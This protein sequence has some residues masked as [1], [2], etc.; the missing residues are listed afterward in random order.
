ML[1]Y[2]ALLFAVLSACSESTATDDPNTVDLSYSF[3]QGLTDWQ[4]GAT[5]IIVG[6]NPIPWHIQPSSAIAFDGSQSL[7]FHMANFTDAAKIWITR[8]V[9][10]QPNKDYHVR[11]SYELATRDWGDAN[12]FSL[13][14]GAFPKPPATAADLE[15]A[16][17]RF[18]T[19]NGASSDVGYRWLHK[20]VESSVRTG[21]DGKAHIVVGVWGTYE[22]TRTYYIDAV[23]IHLE[24]A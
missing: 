21:A 23:R 20:E 15:P 11:V 10:L 8:A 14:T 4:T 5:D 17:I 2:V 7:E 13:L 6:G 12:L 16:F 18:A 22:I 1:R 3:E 24:P 19:G 9:S